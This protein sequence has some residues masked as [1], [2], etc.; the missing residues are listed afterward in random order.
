MKCPECGG[1]LTTKQK[2][3]Q[4][5]SLCKECRLTWFILKIRREGDALYYTRKKEQSREAN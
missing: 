3:G 2:L 1:E 4:G 5:V